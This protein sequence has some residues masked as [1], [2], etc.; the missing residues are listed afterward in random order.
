MGQIEDLRLFTIIVEQG[1]IS[2][3]ADT[4]NIAKS[5]VSRRLSLLEQRYGARL[6]NREPGNWEIT[7]T[8]H[9][10][11]QRVSNVVND[12]DEI[13][14]DFT[15]ATQ[16]L[17][18]PLTVSLP[19]EFGLSF[20]NPSLM[21]FKARH[22]EIQLM[23]DFDDHKVDL[24]RDNYDFA[25]RITPDVGSDIV[26]KR[27][28]SSEHKVFASPSYLA[29]KGTPTS[30]S[31]LKGHDLLQFGPS[32]R[33]NWMFKNI[34]GKAQTF[35]FQPSLNSNSG[36]FLLEATLTG[37]GI[38]RLPD[39]ICQPSIAAGTVIPILTDLVTPEFGIY[40]VHSEGRR[41][42]RRMRLFA[43]QMETACLAQRHQ[44]SC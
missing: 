11:Y 1:S 31:E 32:R 2:R 27:I 37:L 30:L 33:S 17:A 38:A 35:E 18:G 20:L 22:P 10:L 42:N 43:E 29:R 12:V 21:I 16:T 19:R 44:F 14:S 3:A 6:I 8:G 5:A 25:I 36:M 39:F 9:E 7:A 28:G 13:E 41:L 24:S 15:Q 23:V 34:S 40:L 4:I 26:A